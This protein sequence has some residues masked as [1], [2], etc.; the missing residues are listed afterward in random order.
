MTKQ[1]QIYKCNICSNM[2]QVLHAGVG[3]LV[4]HDKPMELL[5]EKTKKDEGKEKHVPIIK[6]TKTGF[7]VMVGSIPHPMEKAHFI[8]WI[9]FFA[10][11]VVL[12][13]YLKPGQKPEAEFK[14]K[15]K[16]VSARIYCNVH[17]LWKS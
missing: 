7:K 4:C 10:D 6:K 17:G 2:V 8:E 9:Q 15:A 5:I 11:D 16:K 3:Q 12:R 1:N 14:V 13:K